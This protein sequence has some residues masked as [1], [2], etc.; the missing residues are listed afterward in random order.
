MPTQNTYKRC[1]LSL[2]LRSIQRCKELAEAR[3]QSVSSLIRLLIAA[4]YDQE[5]STA[6]RR[7]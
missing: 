1:S 2:D 3:S 5:R 6:T 7:P 4:A